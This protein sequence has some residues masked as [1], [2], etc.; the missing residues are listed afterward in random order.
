MESKLKAEMLIHSNL[1]IISNLN[2][3]YGMNSSMRELSEDAN[4]IK[5]IYEEKEYDVNF[6]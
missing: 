6:I 4:F 2:W 5:A 3:L 1:T